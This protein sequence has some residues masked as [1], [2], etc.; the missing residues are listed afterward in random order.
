M[1]KTQFAN[2]EF[3]NVYNRG[4]DKRSIFL[5]KWDFDRFLKSMEEFNAI[6]PIGSIYENSFIKEK[7][8]QKKLVNFIA[9]CLNTN[10]FHFL[11]RQASEQGIEKFMQRLGTGYTKY[12]N[13]RHKRNGILFQGVFK[14]VHVGS[15]NY[16][17]HLSSYINLNFRVHK[18][19][20]EA[21]KLTKS[22]WEEYASGKEGL[23]KKDLV[24]R[25]FKGA[26]EYKNFAEGSLKDILGRKESLREMESL[27]LD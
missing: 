7:P 9:Y 10:H 16:L 2:G 19:G 15:N 24:L 21:S 3:Y 27:L 18:L 12:F 14:V 8:S 11:I 20:S 22:S 4:V 6:D 1:R 13:N 23:C 25:Q 26:A 5:D 17:L